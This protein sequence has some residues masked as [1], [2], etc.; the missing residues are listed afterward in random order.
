MT[1]LWHFKSERIRSS[2]GERYVI[3]VKTSI[4]HVDSSDD[5][6]LS[7]C[8]TDWQPA[9]IA[10]SNPRRHDC[11]PTF[12]W[13][14]LRLLQVVVILSFCNT[15]KARHYFADCREVLSPGQMT[16]LFILRWAAHYSFIIRWIECFCVMRRPR[17]V[18]RGDLSTSKH[19]AVLR[20][21]SRRQQRWRC[22]LGQL[23]PSM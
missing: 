3:Y 4:I 11:E 19:I 15:S 2:R 7:V 13:L 8:S 14:R 17:R 6:R 1:L 12:L 18:P 20:R 21:F 10:L 9:C 23:R 22:L 16:F 5:H